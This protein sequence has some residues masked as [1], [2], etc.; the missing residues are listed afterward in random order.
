MSAGCAGT[1][2]FGEWGGVSLDAA[3]E[4]LV[5][6]HDGYVYD[7]YSDAIEVQ[8]PEPELEP[9]PEP[10]PELKPKARRIPQ[11][12]GAARRR[13]SSATRPTK[14]KRSIC[15]SSSRVESPLLSLECSVGLLR[16]SMGRKVRE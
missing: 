10:E 14:A 11:R 2:F 8:Q 15:C 6:N 5:D 1:P 12:T 7:E 9:E 4:P 13:S 16:C 3:Q